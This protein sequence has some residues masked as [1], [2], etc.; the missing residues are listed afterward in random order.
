M[1]RHHDSRTLPYSA[2]QM[3][4]MVTDIEKYPEFLPWIIA[5][6]VKSDS[7][8]DALADMIVGFK[9]LRE[10]FSCRVLKTRPHLVKVSYIDGPMKHLDNEWRFEDV[11][12]GC[13]VDFMVDF[14][15]KNKMFE[16]LAGQFFDKA[17]RKMTSA[18]E[19]RA[20]ELYAAG[21]EISS[22]G[23]SSSPAG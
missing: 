3:Y 9:G 2:E 19:T 5:L 16:M 23:R 21:K 4:N 18:F 15:F 14:A 12:G 13:R 8:E 20:A 6:R 11:D 1:P 7:E 22:D 17:F 10:T